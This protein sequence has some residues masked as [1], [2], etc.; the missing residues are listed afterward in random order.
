MLITI[1]TSD[2]L[3]HFNQPYYHKMSRLTLGTV[4]TLAELTD[5]VPV[6]LLAFTAS[7]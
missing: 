3:I 4:A 5:I 2:L 7:V 6:E 1:R